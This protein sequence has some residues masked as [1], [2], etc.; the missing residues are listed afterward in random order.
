[1]KITLK[2]WRESSLGSNIVLGNLRGD[3]ADKD[4]MVKVARIL[5]LNG[6]KLET[7]QELKIF[8]GLEE[9]S[10]MNNHNK[11]IE[12]KMLLGLQ[13]E[14]TKRITEIACAENASQNS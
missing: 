10:V 12:L 8:V 14:I 9:L 4:T 3:M 7:E 1:M 5:L 2:V 11:N 13:Q 6:S